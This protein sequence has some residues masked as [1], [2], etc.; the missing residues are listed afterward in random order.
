MLGKWQKRRA[1]NR[2]CVRTIVTLVG[3]AGCAVLF[4]AMPC[5]Q[6]AS[7]ERSPNIVFQEVSRSAGIAFRHQPAAFDPRLS[8]LMPWL[9]AGG[10]GVSVA[11]YN[12]DGLD[13]I[14]F[15]NNKSGSKNHLYRNEGHFKFVEVAGQAGLADLNHASETGVSTL[16]LWFDYDN[17]GWKDLLLL[18]IGNASLFHNNRNGTFTDVSGKSGVKRLI[19][20]LSAVAFDYDRDGYVDL[21]IAGYFP[22]KDFFHLKD[23]KVLFDS[24]ETA[25]N[26]GRNVLLRNQG[27]GTFKDVTDF[28]GVGDTGWTMAVAHGDF[29]NDGWQDLYSAN[30]FGPDKMFR[31][32]GNGRFSDVTANAIG[33]DT[34]KGMN[35][36]V[37]DYNNDGLLDI[38]VTNMTEPYLEECNMLWRNKGDMTFTDVSQETHSCDTGWGWGAKFLDVDNDGDLDLYVANGFL[39]AGTG[40]Y[41]DVLLDF[42]FVQGIDLT[43]VS[44]WPKMG[45]RSMGGREHN[46]LF[47]Q[48]PQGF[49]SIGKSAGVDNVSDT[50]SVAIADFDHDGR[51]DMVIST[52]NSPPALYR[53]T[54]DGG[55]HWIELKLEGHGA[56]SNRD[57]IGSRVRVQTGSLS[58]IREVASGN[59]FESQSSLTQHF[60]LSAA[61]TI[62]KITVTWPDGA[63]QTFSHVAVDKF[64]TLVQGGKLVF[65]K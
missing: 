26:G 51:M 59:G 38:Y 13:D 46:V 9:T 41:M 7:V 36:E 33:V 64:Y 30:D 32:L 11:D 16:G 53:N 2:R 6:A 58:Q 35:A 56:H 25:R 37:G 10:A 23:S 44:Q 48:T 49:R 54:T 28:A 43:D 31:N 14:F 27:D 55:G 52:I 1:W 19:N 62:D 8:N 17:D 4:W 24:W 20:A 22:E 60:G 63:S 39:S 47:E 61:K 65:G 40:E 12:N 18:R 5:V 3:G 29:D 34:K 21:Y 50:R 57:A 42:I 45:D 15:T